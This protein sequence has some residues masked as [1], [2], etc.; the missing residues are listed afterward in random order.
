MVKVNTKGKKKI[1]DIERER[2]HGPLITHGVSLVY[3]KLY[4]WIG[5]ALSGFMYLVGSYEDNIGIFKGL[6]LLCGVVNIFGIII[7]FIPYF[8]NTWKTLTYYLI[9][10]TV[11]SLVIGFDFIGLLMVISDGSP[12]GAKEI[13]QSPLTPFYVIFILLLFIFACGLYAW[14]YLPKNQGK[15]W[16]FNEVK[17]GDRKKTWW[18]NFAVAFAGA[19]TIPSLL[20]GYIQNAFGILLGILLTLTL[21]AVM[22][23]AVYA[24]IYV[25]KHPNSDELA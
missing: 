4:P 3:I 9:A 1:T 10:L 21:P 19:T 11:L 14:H 13:Y 25:K 20:T 15:V 23:D 22:V 6:S 12:I 2:Y 18:N 16:A 24:A 7:S 8:V 5:L 17:E